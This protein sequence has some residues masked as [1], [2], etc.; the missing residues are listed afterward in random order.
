MR[1]TLKDYQEEAVRDVLAHLEKAKRRWRQ[2]GDP[3]AFSLSA[4]TGAGKTVMAAA[5]IEALFYGSAEHDIVPDPTAT[6]LWFSD[7]PSL[8]AQ[9]K[10]RLHEAS[11]RLEPSRLVTVKNSFSQETFRPGHVYFLNTQ[12]LSSNSLLVRGFDADAESAGGLALRPDGRSHT[13]W[14]TI[15]NTVED[16]ERTLILLLDEAHRGVQGAV[17]GRD[18]IVT[19]L[20]AGRGSVPGIPVVWGISAT[21][22]RFEEAIRNIETLDRMSPV[23]VDAQKV[24]A[25]GLLKD[26]LNLDVPEASGAVETVLLRRGAAK[27]RQFSN[28]WAEYAKEQGASEAVKPLL[29]LQ[30]PNTPD[31]DEIGSWLQIIQDEW[32]ELASDSFA[33]VFGEHRKE[34]FGPFEVPYIAPERVEESD[35][36]RV[37]VAKDAISTGW[38]CPRAEV[39]VSFRAASDR[40]HITQL[41]GRMVRTPLARRIPGNELLN[42]VDCLLPRFNR[43]TVEQVVEVLMN[44]GD[45]A[46]GDHSDKRILINPITLGPNPDVPKAVW[47]KFETLPSQ[48]LPQRRKRPVARLYRLA[49]ALARDGLVEGAAKTVTGLM[50][51]VLDG[52]AVQ[53]ADMVA[54]ERAN[55]LRV[56]GATLQADLQ[57]REKSFDAFV[58]DADMAVIDHYY[59]AAARRFGGDLTRAYA[60]LLADRIAGVKGWEG[61]DMDALIE[62]RTDIA[63]LGLVEDIQRNLDAEADRITEAWLG[64]H[65]VAIKSLPDTQQ[66]TYRSVREATPN[67]QPYELVRPESAQQMTEIRNPDGTVSALPRF[68]RHLLCDTD[69][70]YPYKKSDLNPDEENIVRTELGR[71]SVTAWYRNP[72]RSGQ[73]SLGIVYEKDG[74]SKI[75]YPDLLVFAEAEDGSVHA[76]IVDP[77]STHLADALPKLHGLAA[78][79]ESYGR[80]FRRIDSLANIDGELRVLDIQEPAVREAVSLA[81]SAKSLFLGPHSD[82]Y[83]ILAQS[84]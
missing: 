11:D 57:T 5:V 4:T 1:F 33:N 44:G 6:V 61:D 45:D 47:A 72:V 31:P 83:D 22:E 65:R 77:H 66:E 43:E 56:D 13:I 58:E 52:A 3:Q 27:L 20:I 78:Y 14:E 50:H 74:V 8:N 41:L 35:W 51:D 53:F 16:P 48:S 54:T 75:F 40:T 15:R 28:A 24:Q 2:D 39:M 67:P 36:I 46:T 7:D 19:R 62:A 73:E 81:S 69:G 26:T 68:D 21:V 84:P 29:V 60:D 64:N 80:L 37:L 49:D 34:A 9:S 17:R 12:K 32:P 23:T 42:S 82:R 76:D 55:V 79:A 70:T 59:N 38:D 18:T 25:S 30:V 10:Y 63:A 71:P